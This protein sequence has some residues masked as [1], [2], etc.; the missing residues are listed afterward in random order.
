MMKI[1]TLSRERPTYIEMVYYMYEELRSCHA[2]AKAQNAIRLLRQS[3]LCGATHDYACEPA[4]YIRRDGGCDGRFGSVEGDT[5]CNREHGV[6]R[7][8]V[9]TPDAP[10]PPD[11]NS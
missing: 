1:T 10:K 6:I 9:F 4:V 7:V 3:C 11:A 8:A 2:P 5:K